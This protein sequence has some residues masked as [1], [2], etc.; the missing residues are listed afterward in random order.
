MDSWIVQC[1]GMLKN[2]VLNRVYIAI[3]N[4]DSFKTII[5]FLMK[6]VKKE[7]F[8]CTTSPKCDPYWTSTSFFMMMMM[9]H[10]IFGNRSQASWVKLIILQKLFYHGNFIIRYEIDLIH[11]PPQIFLHNLDKATLVAQNYFIMWA[12]GCTIITW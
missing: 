11:A 2:A 3:D 8:Q 7:S 10:N 5:D 9:I 6:L 4:M 12:V 1:S